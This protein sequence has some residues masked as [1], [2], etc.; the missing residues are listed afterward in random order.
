MKEEREKMKNLDTYFGDISSAARQILYTDE[1]GAE[2]NESD[3]YQDIFA[4][5]EDLK[6]SGGVLYF[7]GNGASAS[8]ASHFALD[9]FKTAQIKT[10]TFNDMSALTAIG[11]D[12]SFDDVFSFP[13]SQ[14]ITKNDILCTVSSSGNSPNIIKGIEAALKQEA[15]VITLSGMKADNKSRQKGH[16]NMFFPGMDYG[17]TECAHS[18]MLH[19]ILDTFVLK[20]L[21]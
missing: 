7:I 10:N 17:P 8:I 15:F 5:L 1:M 19:Y 9:Y 18:I 3:N 13:I 21:N 14:L 12:I 20:Y 4:R 16:I 6:K 11:N 2:I